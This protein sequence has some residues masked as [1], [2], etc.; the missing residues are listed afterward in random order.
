MRLADTSDDVAA[1]GGILQDI[2]ALARQ[3]AETAPYKSASGPDALRALAARLDA[4]LA[5]PRRP[6]PAIS[7]AVRAARNKPAR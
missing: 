4:M 6:Q 5:P 2:A 3:L 7:V 1:A